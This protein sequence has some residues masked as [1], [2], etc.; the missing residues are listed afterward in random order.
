MAYDKELDKVFGKGNAA[1]RGKQLTKAAKTAAGSS[2]SKGTVAKATAKAA[3]KTVAEDVAKTAGT[4]GLKSAG[5][6]LGP[7][8]AVGITAYDVIKNNNIADKMERYNREIKPIFSD[9][10]IK[11]YRNKAKTIGITSGLGTGIGAGLGAW[12]TLG[13]GAPVGAVGGLGVGSTVGDLGYSLLAKKPNTPWDKKYDNELV[14]KYLAKKN[15]EKQKQPMAQAKPTATVTTNNTRTYNGGGNNKSYVDLVNEGISKYGGFNP[16]EMYGT[17]QPQIQQQLQPQQ[18]YIQP[19]E[20]TGTEE[21]EQPQY[22]TQAILDYYNNVQNR[23]NEYIKK[24]EDFYDN[25]DN[26]RLANIDR[27]MYFNALAGWTGNDRWSRMGEYVNPMKDEA[28]RLKIYK[29]LIDAQNENDKAP[30]NIAGNMALM[31]QM[32]VDPS[33]AMADPRMFGQAMSMMRAQQ[34]IQA[35]KQIAL[36]NAKE[37]D[38]D[39]QLK[40]AIADGRRQD[41]ITLQSMKNQAAMDKATLTAIGFGIDP[42][43]MYSAMGALGYNSPSGQ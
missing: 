5:K 13:F 39:R 32:G 30:M 42:N 23:N 2:A 35:R 9:D 6:W 12:T 36:L 4:T 14:Q 3:G 19:Q 20:I 22:D 29:E 8:A 31:K 33:M 28:L 17:Q 10:D 38:L 24:L 41:A 15:A 43:T 27:Q 37:K 34:Q 26:N 7:G 21:M 18:S 25:Y 40:A 1:T 11:Y 16:E